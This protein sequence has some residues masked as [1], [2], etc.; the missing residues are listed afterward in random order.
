MQTPPV[1]VRE[2]QSS[3]LAHAS[4]RV[5]QVTWPGSGAQAPFASVFVQHWSA[6]VAA[7]PEAMHAVDPQA[8]F[9]H[10]SEQQSPEDAQLEP[11]ALQKPS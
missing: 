2:Q 7:E 9:T 11:F 5:L 1:H 10:D 4:P 8:P 3:P 6:V